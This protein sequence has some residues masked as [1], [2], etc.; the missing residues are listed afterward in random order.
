MAASASPPPVAVSSA[1]DGWARWHAV[2]QALAIG[3]M[4]ST[5]LVLSR[6]SR[7]DN[8]AGLNTTLSV[9]VAGLGVLAIAYAIS[10]FAREFEGAGAVYEYLTHGAHPASASSSQASSSSAPCSWA[11]AA[12]TSASASSPT[13][14]GRS[15]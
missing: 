13:A 8:G 15:T 14:S 5:A 7:P 9:L 1:N 4:F 6:V 2:A 11:A 12:S 3:P 10:L